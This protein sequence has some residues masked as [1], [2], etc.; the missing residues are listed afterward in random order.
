MPSST[1]WRGGVATGTYAALF[2]AAVWTTVPAPRR[3]GYSFAGWIVEGAEIGSNAR[4]SVV[5]NERHPVLAGTPCGAGY[6]RCSFK[7][8]TNAGGAVRL[9]AQW[10]SV[11]TKSSQLKAI[12]MQMAPEPLVV[13]GILDDGFGWFKMTLDYGL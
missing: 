1:I 3:D 8:L 4:Y 2:K 11:I 7:E 13:E 12:S 9:T 6:S 5:A 10:Q